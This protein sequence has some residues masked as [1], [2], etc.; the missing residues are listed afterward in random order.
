MCRTQKHHWL[1]LSVNIM[2]TAWP[3]YDS[4]CACLAH[5]ISIRFVFVFFVLW[6][7]F[8][9]FQDAF[10]WMSI[11]SFDSCLEK[12]ITF[13]YCFALSS[14]CRGSKHFEWWSVTSNTD[15]EFLLPQFV[16]ARAKRLTQY[17]SLLKL[18]QVLFKIRSVLW[19][20]HRLSY[21]GV[22]VFWRNRGK[23]CHIDNI[24]QCALLNN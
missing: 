16:L 20:I 5:K 18:Q 21:I 12:Q 24:M 23:L 8:L 15:F 19:I 3:L 10:F 17:C 2:C 7:A 11:V 13:C 4:A 9:T 22:S 6:I 1:C 14:C